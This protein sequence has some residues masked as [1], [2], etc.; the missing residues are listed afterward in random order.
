VWV[1]EDERSGQLM[2]MFVEK[3]IVV[4]KQGWKR[5]CEDKLS[6]VEFGVGE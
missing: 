5:V 6:P 2:V 1:N 4:H 3:T